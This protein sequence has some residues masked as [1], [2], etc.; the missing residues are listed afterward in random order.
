MK[1]NQWSKIPKQ[2]C[3]HLDERLRDRNITL[4][5]LD[6]LRIWLESQPEVPEGEWFK[7]F[8][9]FKLTG[10]GPNPTTFLAPGMIAY[11]TEIRPEDE[12][13]STTAR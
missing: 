10:F 7:D 5:D 1:L 4:E 11:G 2:I 12:A 6:R 8:G 9:S 13:G 3:Q